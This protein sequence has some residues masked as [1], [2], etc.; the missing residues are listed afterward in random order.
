MAKT[1]LG[2]IGLGYV[3]RI[4]LQNCLKLK[5]AQLTAVADVSKQALKVARKLGIPNTYE[6]YLELL[7]KSNVD[8]VIIALP[9]HLHAESAKAAAECHKHVLLEKPL[10]RNTA[11]G[12]EIL[13]AANKHNIKLAIGY[14]LRFSPPYQE[15]KNRIESGELGEIQIA[16][17]ADIGTGPF[18]HRAGTDAP[19]PVPEWR[20]KKEL[21]GGGA[22][23]DQG[24]HMINLTRWYFGNV[25]EAK[26]YL[27]HRLNLEQEDHAICLLKFDRGQ[28]GLINVGWFSMQNRLEIEVYGTAGHA[29]TTCN[30][31]RRIETALRLLLRKT[32]SLYMP[33]L[34]EIQH[35]VDC[36]Q[37][38]EQPQSSGEDALKDLE[39]I[40]RAYA[41]QVRLN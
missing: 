32:P 35:F 6:N 34:R 15:L 39:V 38:D 22:L 2:L 5:K 28:I 14:A 4:H 41:N 17:A 31:P 11:E 33:Y 16:Y 10:A 20:W 21:T 37:K 8:A 25:V 3:G 30:Q 12:K 40:E 26:S 24:S 19:T 1:S 9:T 36:I 23:L 18:V 7:N 27:G 13:D 29:T